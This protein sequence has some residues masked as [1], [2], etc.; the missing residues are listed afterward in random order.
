MKQGMKERIRTGVILAVL[1][2][3]VLWIGGAVLALVVSVLVAL[4]IHEEYAALRKAG[5]RTVSWPTWA[6]MVLALPLAVTAGVKMVIPLLMAVCILT[7]LC[8]MFRKEPA[9]EDV[10]MSVLPLFT[11]LLPGMCLMSLVGVDPKSLQV[12]LITTVIVV[13]SVG[14]IFAY[15]V[16]SRLGGPKFCPAVSPKKTISGAIAGLA[17]AVLAGLIMWLLSWVLCTAEV[18]L[19]LPNFFQFLFLGLLGGVMGQT[20]DLCFSLI[21]RHCGIKDYGNLF[22]G[23]GG[24][25]DRM[26]SVLFMAMLVYCYRL[27]TVL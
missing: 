17:G 12:V 5:H 10:T 9:L 24:V 8:V 16:G 2:V 13:P 3:L 11:V 7:L 1:A 22:P 27:M 6:G 19:M 4:G 26:D 20:G 15:F 23:H 25:L 14:D 21:K 18:R